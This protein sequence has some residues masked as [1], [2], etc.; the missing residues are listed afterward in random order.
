LPAR[1]I[2]WR[3]LGIRPKR[4]RGVLEPARGYGTHLPLI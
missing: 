2:K 1:R 3:N 4:D